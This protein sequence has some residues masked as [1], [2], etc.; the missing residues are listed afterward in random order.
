MKSVSCF[1]HSLS[2][3]LSRQ[4]QLFFSGI[5]SLWKCSCC[6]SFFKCACSPSTWFTV[7]CK[8]SFTL[9]SLR[10]RQVKGHLPNPNRGTCRH[11][12]YSSYPCLDLAFDMP[13]KHA[14][15]MSKSAYRTFYSSLF[16]NT[17]IYIIVLIWQT[18]FSIQMQFFHFFN[19][20]FK[21]FDLLFVCPFFEAI[22]TNF[23]L[24][25][26]FDNQFN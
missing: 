24:Q 19:F 20:V 7:L 25:R 18:W 16:S 1:Q 9:S 15:S 22:I 2:N 14:I 11:H 4:L 6:F 17:I 26:N 13:F 8:L 10:N 12:S 5:S 23:S 3:S 21:Q